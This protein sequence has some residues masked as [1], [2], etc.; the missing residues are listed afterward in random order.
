VNRFTEAFVPKLA[1]GDLK[2]A[3]DAGAVPPRNLRLR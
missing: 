3:L 2:E 1:E